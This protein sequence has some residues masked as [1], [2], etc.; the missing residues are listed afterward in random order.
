MRD[1]IALPEAGKRFTNQDSPSKLVKD[2]ITHYDSSYQDDASVPWPGSSG[3]FRRALEERFGEHVFTRRLV[4]GYLADTPWSLRLISLGCGQRSAVSA[5]KGAWPGA[6]VA[7]PRRRCNVVHAGC[8]C[9]NCGAAS[10]RMAACCRKIHSLQDARR[11][12]LRVC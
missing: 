2:R 11:W 5:H 3:A 12:G 4:S 9:E 7:T 1:L 10:Q 6:V 8:L